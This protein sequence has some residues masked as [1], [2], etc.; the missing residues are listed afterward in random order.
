MFRERART[1]NL[2]C[3]RWYVLSVHGRAHNWY[4]CFILHDLCLYCSKEQQNDLNYQPREVVKYLC[5][6]VFAV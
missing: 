1:E 5:F 2:L 6:G 4:A 3:S